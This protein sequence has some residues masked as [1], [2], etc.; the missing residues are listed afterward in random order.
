VQP[1]DAPGRRVQVSE[2]G[3][4]SAW[5]SRDSRRLTYAADD[6]RSLWGVAIAPGAANVAGAPRQIASLPPDVVYV[7]MMP[8]ES[9]FLVL[10]PEGAGTGSITI[11][12]NWRAA[13][14]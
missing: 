11:V 6:L 13:I 8:D 1:F 12:Q 10:Q 9:R 7:A 5:W 4:V 3:G 2:R 14:R